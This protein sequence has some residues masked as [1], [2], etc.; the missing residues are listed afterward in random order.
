MICI[1]RF[2]IIHEIDLKLVA[3]YDER[4]TIY[5]FVSINDCHLQSRPIDKKKGFGSNL[6]SKCQKI[7]I[8]S[9]HSISKP[10]YK[11]KCP[12]LAYM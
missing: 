1:I 2:A 7:I 9:P 5:D 12:Y 10:S 8:T 6:T 4:F 11:H 3:K